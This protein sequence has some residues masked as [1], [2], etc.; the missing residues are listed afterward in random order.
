MNIKKQ[1]INTKIKELGQKLGLDETTSITAKRNAKNI[2]AL[3]AITG[4]I[5]VLG[6]FMT[7]PVLP[8]YYYGGGSVKDF[9]LIFRG[10]F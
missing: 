7:V 8:G 3:A 2:I 10:L 1:K 6:T 5:L 9:H 4:A